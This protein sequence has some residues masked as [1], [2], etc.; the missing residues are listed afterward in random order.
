MMDQRIKKYFEAT[1][2]L[3]LSYIPQE[4]GE[5]KKYTRKINSLF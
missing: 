1:K 3:E 2:N 5:N 4:E